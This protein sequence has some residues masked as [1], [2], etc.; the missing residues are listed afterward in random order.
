LLLPSAVLSFFAFIREGL[1]KKPILSKSFTGLI[2]KEF[3]DIYMIKRDSQKIC[4][5]HRG[6]PKEK[7]EKEIYRCC[8]ETIQT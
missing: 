6:Y 7:I 3:D 1:S 2:V 8:W 4:Q 5:I